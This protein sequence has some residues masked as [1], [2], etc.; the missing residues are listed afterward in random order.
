MRDEREI[1]TRQIISKKLIYE[2]KRSMVGALF[3]SILCAL[4]FGMFNLLLLSAHHV[5]P[6]TRLAVNLLQLPVYAVCVFFFVRA[7]INI[8][9]TN[10]GAF[11]VTEEELV[12]VKDN[13]FSLLS[14]LSLLQLVFCGGLDIIFGNKSHLRHV[15][16]FKSGKKFVANVE[17]YKNTRLGVAAQFSMPG[18]TFFIVCYNDAPSK[19]ILLFSSKTYTYKD[20]D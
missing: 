20:N 19:I 17:E 4:V 5:S 6:I 14:L 16:E 10:R 1:L 3:I 15:F 11:N 8:C 18:D 7:I 12:S 2:A 9:K 13:E